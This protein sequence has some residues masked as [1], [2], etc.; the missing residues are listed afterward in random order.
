[1]TGAD[2][3]GIGTVHYRPRVS[4]DQQAANELAKRTLTNLSNQMPAWLKQAHQELDEAVFAAYGLPSSLT[5]DEILARLLDL[6]MRRA[7]PG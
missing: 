7:S 6:S 1:V 5:D 3:R 2:E 4:K